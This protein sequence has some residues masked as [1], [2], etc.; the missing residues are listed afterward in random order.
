MFEELGSQVGS[1]VVVSRGVATGCDGIHKQQVRGEVIEGESGQQ[2][3]NS[4][5]QKFG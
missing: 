4:A 1:E 3:E 5:V 2:S